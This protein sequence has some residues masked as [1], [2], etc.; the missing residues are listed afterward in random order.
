MTLLTHMVGWSLF[1]L[2]A[3]LW[4]LGIQQRPLHSGPIAHA[5]A[6]GSFAGIGYFSYGYQERSR[7][8][9]ADI[10]SKVSQRQE[11]RTERAKERVS[12]V[13][14]ALDAKKANNSAEDE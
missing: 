14:A 13:K 6:M 2:G 4:H 10:R 1:G 11:E 8:I 3:R 9:L 12:Q 5:V 7:E